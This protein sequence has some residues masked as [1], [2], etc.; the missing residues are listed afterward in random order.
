[1]FLGTLLGK[2]YTYVQV[3]I[4]VKPYQK[5]SENVNRFHNPVFLNKGIDL[6]KSLS[7]TF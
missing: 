7:D 3:L 6:K 1:M 4:T 2:C 5:A